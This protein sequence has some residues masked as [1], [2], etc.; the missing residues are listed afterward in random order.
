M[1]SC[2]HFSSPPAFP[3]PL[4]CTFYS[5][6]SH[7][8]RKTGCKQPQHRPSAVS[9]TLTWRRCPSAGGWKTP[10]LWLI[11]LWC[12]WRSRKRGSPPQGTAGPSK[13]PCVDS[14]NW[15]NNICEI[16]WRLL[17]CGMILMF[18]FKSGLK[19]RMLQKWFYDYITLWEKYANYQN[20]KGSI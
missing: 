14:V 2:S 3:S 9:W 19:Y 18:L 8:A 20:G 4:H 17:L 1:Q 16:Q 10:P 13:S 5:Q 11:L 12:W 6:S 15:F 7:P